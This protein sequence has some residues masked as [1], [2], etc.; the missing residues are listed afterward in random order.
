MPC[1]YTYL[2]FSVMLLAEMRKAT[3]P[4]AFDIRVPAAN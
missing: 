3:A 2:P 1:S 4:V